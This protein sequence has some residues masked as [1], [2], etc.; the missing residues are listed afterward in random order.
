MPHLYNIINK[1][2]EGCRDGQTRSLFTS[3]SFEAIPT[4]AL[5]LSS[6]N[7]QIKKQEF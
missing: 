2:I 3:Q 4:A 1:D 7:P 6:I 5:M